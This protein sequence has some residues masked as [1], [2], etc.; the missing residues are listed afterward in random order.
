MK[1]RP[2][3]LVRFCD[4]DPDLTV[5]AITCRRFA[6]L[7]HPAKWQSRKQ[8]I[9]AEATARAKRE[10]Q[11][12]KPFTDYA[13]KLRTTCWDNRNHRKRKSPP[14]SGCVRRRSTPCRIENTLALT[15]K[16]RE[17]SFYVSV[18]TRRRPDDGIQTGAGPTRG[19]RG[20]G[21]T[22]L[23]KRRPLHSS[24]EQLQS[25]VFSTLPPRCLPRNSSMA[26]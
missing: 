10:W 8:A 17:G 25:T 2:S 13:G 3:G 15:P 9:A 14:C 26:R 20:V 16:L 7:N 12:T 4:R 19:R 23:S 6:P 22:W 24:D 5:G 18:R 11:L 1:C 21:Q